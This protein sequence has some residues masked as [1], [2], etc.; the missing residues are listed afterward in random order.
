M[1]GVLV[2]RPYPAPHGRSIRR[3]RPLQAQVLP[4]LYRTP[5]ITLPFL[6]WFLIG[7]I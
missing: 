7:L 6:S 1:G 5:S 4:A 3:R 2:Q